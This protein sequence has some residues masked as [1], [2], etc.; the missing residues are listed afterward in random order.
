MSITKNYNKSYGD[1]TTNVVGT[2]HVTIVMDGDMA[3]G[4]R[5][6]AE[7]ERR[8][9]SQTALAKRIGISQAAL[10]KIE[11]GE[12][13]KSKWLPELMNALSIPMSGSQPEAPTEAPSEDLALLRQSL[14]QDIPVKGVAVGGNDADFS[15]NGAISEY[16]RRPPGLAK[17][18]GV[19][20]VHVVSDSM[21]PKYE[22]SDLL[23]VSSTRAPAVGD[24]VVVELHE[25]EDGTPGKGFIKRLVKRSGSVIKLHQFNPDAD[26]EIETVLIRSI[27]RVFSNNEMFGA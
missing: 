1:A 27:H 5:I 18:L 7:R 17:A 23:F 25:Q 11:S 6:R 15:F 10:A 21:S 16:V 2:G 20:A 4:E 8:G 22:P 26:I 14:P 19:Y 12:T 24:Y 3:V 9:W 13:A